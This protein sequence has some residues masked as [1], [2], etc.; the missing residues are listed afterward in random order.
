MM[1]GTTNSAELKSG[2]ELI[3][4]NHNL[5]RKLE[6]TERLLNAILAD[7]AAKDRAAR[8]EEKKAQCG[9]GSAAASRIGRGDRAC[10][11]AKAARL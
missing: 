5:S 11:T 3:A 10:R 1:I 8:E 9:R 4:E 7:Q 6:D 2:V